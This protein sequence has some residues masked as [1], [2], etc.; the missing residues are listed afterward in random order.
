MKKEDKIKEILK[1]IKYLHNYCHIMP[2]C[3]VSS[4]LFYIFTELNNYRLK[5]KK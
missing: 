1:D 4:Q 5:Y 3:K 2:M